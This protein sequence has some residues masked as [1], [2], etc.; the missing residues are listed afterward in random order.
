ME[1]MKNSAN[2]LQMA[3]PRITEDQNVAKENEHKLANE[4]MEH[5]I[6]H[7]LE[8]RWS[9][10]Q[11]ERHDQELEVPVMGA[12]RCLGNVGFM[13]AHLMVAAPQ[14]QLGEVPRP[15]AIH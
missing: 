12:E 1:P 8:C 15:R 4:I 2:M 3:A 7:R 9:I 5:I 13:H 14:I 10:G 11:A 6:H